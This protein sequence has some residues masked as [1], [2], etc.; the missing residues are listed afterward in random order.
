MQDEYGVALGLIEE[1]ESVS[2]KD[3]SIVSK[4]GGDSGT[5]P[6]GKDAMG[7]GGWGIPVK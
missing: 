2:D 1:G 5:S 6:G 3:W 7:V 4:K